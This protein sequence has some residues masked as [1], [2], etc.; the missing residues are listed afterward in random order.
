MTK[1]AQRHTLHSFHQRLSSCRHRFS[2]VAVGKAAAATLLIGP[3]LFGDPLAGESN[4]RGEKGTKTDTAHR[5]NKQGTNERSVQ[6][7]RMRTADTD[8][9]LIYNAIHIQRLEAA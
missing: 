5:S 8:K 2:R 3:S 7:P 4:H 6:L 1:S 9:T